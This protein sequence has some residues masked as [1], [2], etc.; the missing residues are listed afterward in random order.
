VIRV[1]ENH[2]LRRSQLEDGRSNVA[3]V[4]VPACFT[5]ERSGEV[6]VRDG[7][8]RGCVQP[9]RHGQDDPAIGVLLERAAAIAES[10]VFGHEP[11]ELTGCTIEHLDRGNDVRELLSVGPD[12]LDGCRA[13]ST[14]NPRQCLDA[15]PPLA[16]GHLHDGV[17]RFSRRHGDVDYV[18]RCLDD[19][20]AVG[21]VNDRTGKA[22]VRDDDVA[23]AAE[24]EDRCRGVVA[25]ANRLD[26]LLDR[27]RN[28][29]GISRT[30]DPKRRALGEV[31][32]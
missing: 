24:Q 18:V 21:Y 8:G 5:A 31:R 30:A 17:P 6:A 32:G 19:D 22:R 23:A 28:K 12:I 16:H 15:G 25:L 29:P 1:V 7:T 2:A 10:A 27:R 13:G 4:G 3:D 14:G 20:T 9:Q 26:D 11:S